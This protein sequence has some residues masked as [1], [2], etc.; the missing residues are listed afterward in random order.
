M[1][2]W[3]HLTVSPGIFITLLFNVGLRKK[4]RQRPIYLFTL[5]QVQLDEL[6]PIPLGF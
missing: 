2:L 5:L 4:V 3:V 6:S 1:R